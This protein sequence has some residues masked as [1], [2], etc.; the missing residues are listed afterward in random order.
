M[1]Y[2]GPPSLSADRAAAI[3]VVLSSLL[4]CAELV[5]WAMVLMPNR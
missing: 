2:P 3:L 4:L 5:W 1:N